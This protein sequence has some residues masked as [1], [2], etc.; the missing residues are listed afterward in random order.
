MFIVT[1]YAALTSIE[2]YI[3]NATQNVHGGMSFGSGEKRDFYCDHMIWLMH[4]TWA[5]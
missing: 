2:Q 5:I 1:E 3:H 4:L